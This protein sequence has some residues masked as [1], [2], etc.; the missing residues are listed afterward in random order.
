L[1]DAS[2][3][4]VEVDTRTYD[5]DTLTRALEIAAALGADTLRT[6]VSIPDELHGAALGAYM[7]PGGGLDDDLKQAIPAIQSVLPLCERYGIRLALENHE[8]ETSAQVIALVRALDSEWVGILIDTGNMMTVWEDPVAA[9]AAMAPWAI[10]TH[11]KDHAVILDGDA[12]YVVGVPLGRGTI[13]LPACC[14]V[15][16]DATTLMRLCIEVCYGY[17]AAF[18]LPEGQGGGERLGRGAFRLMS[19]P[20]DPACVAPYPNYRNPAHLPPAD[21]ARFLQWVDDAVVESVAYV[22][23]LV[24]ANATPVGK[25]APPW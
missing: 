13:D 9:V 16:S 7:R 20:Y 25:P 21:G 12:P 15:L 19:P 8:Y 11:V 17:R 2:G 3:L 18:R 1:C 6:Y 14:R 5:R 23:T 24:K 4:F 10:S 22:K